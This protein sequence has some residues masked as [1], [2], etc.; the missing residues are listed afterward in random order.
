MLVVF[1]GVLVMFINIV[2]V[3]F[4]LF[5]SWCLFFIIVWFVFVSFV[6]LLLWLNSLIRYSWCLNG[7]LRVI[8]YDC[9]GWLLFDMSG[10]SWFIVVVC[11]NVVLMV[12]FRCGMDF[13][14]V[15]FFGWFYIWGC[16]WMFMIEIG[17]CMMYFVVG[18][19]NGM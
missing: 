16:D 9:W 10:N 4:C 6:C 2:S 13:Y 14:L 12:V 18:V 15:M 1:K 5:K 17:Y 19:W 8:V 11:I 3:M 7:C